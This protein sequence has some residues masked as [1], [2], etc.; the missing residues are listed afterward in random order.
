MK[1]L[2]QSKD[3]LISN[4]I[5]IIKLATPTWNNSTSRG[6]RIRSYYLLTY[7]LINWGRGRNRLCRTTAIR[8]PKQV[9]LKKSR[10]FV[11][12]LREIM[13]NNFCRTISYRIGWGIRIGTTFSTPERDRDRM[14]TAVR[15]TAAVLHQK[16]GIISTCKSSTSILAEQAHLMGRPKVYKLS[17]LTAFWCFIRILYICIHITQYTYV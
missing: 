12:S 11:I 4:W 16:S 6:I 17:Q 10:A 14:H 7:K 2:T 3:F 15:S 1:R 13:R 9:L 8:D 5:E